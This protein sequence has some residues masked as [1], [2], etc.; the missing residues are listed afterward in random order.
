[1]KKCLLLCVGILA[2]VHSGFSGGSRVK[3]CLD[4]GWKFH[5]GDLSGAESV[6]LDDRDWRSLNVPHDWSIEGEYDKNHPSGQWGGYLPGGVGWYRKTLAVPESWQG[7]HVQLDFDGV[8]RKS[9]VYVDGKEVGYRPYGWISFSYDISDVIL[10]K[11]EVVIAVRVDNADQPAARWYTGSGIYAHTWLTVTNRLHVGEWGP[12]V[13]SSINGKSAALAIETPVMNAQGKD[14]SF[15]I[16]QE[17]MDS[18]GKMVAV[19]DSAQKLAAG[20]SE[21]YNQSLKLDDPRPWSLEDPYLYTLVTSI[22]AD[23]RNIDQYETPVGLRTIEWDTDTGFYLNGKNIKIRGVADH[24]G[25][26]P[27]GSAVPD[28]IL[29]ERLLQL[30]DMG[31]NS[32]RTAHY[33]RPPVFYEICNEIGLLVMD[34]IFDGWLKKADQDY[35]AQDFDQWW[36]RDLSDW[37]KR[38]RNHPC[39]FIY[40]VGNETRGPFAEEM[41]SLCHA[42]D[43]TRKV[44][45]GSSAEEH[46]DV[47]GENGHSELRSYYENHD[48]ELPFIAT[49]AP[50]TWQ[51]R[52][53]YRTQTWYRDGLTKDPQLVPDLT[54]SE[55]FHYEWA[56]PE[57]VL[58]SKQVLNSSYDN[59]FVRVSARDYEAMVNELPYHSGQ[60]RWTGFD[61]LGEAKIAHGA[62]PFK[63]FMGGA[64]DLVGFPKDLFYF[65]QSRWTEE[66]MVHMLPIGPIL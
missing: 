20:E 63:A 2:V 21:T 24:W 65:Y 49:E 59:A 28:K 36:K 22:H 48:F 66:P 45:S 50:H 62:W 32:V 56:D 19:V 14:A 38:D 41:V 33:P 43:P 17:L 16:K 5:L 15:V 34:E 4:F 27:L 58:T 9:T 8:F 47:W 55:I 30:K 29:R 26:G 51:V 6:N 13:K 18:Q 25:A 42:L 46:M 37:V 23:G 10:G 52:G 35:G 54:P 1:M 61:Y 12:F 40:S 7:K 64:L 60:Y 3:E 39:I 31:V 53:Y 11:K 57:T 44:T